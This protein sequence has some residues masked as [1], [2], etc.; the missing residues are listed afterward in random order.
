[1]AKIV[2]AKIQ[3]KVAYT[4]EDGTPGEINAVEFRCV[5]KDVGAGIVGSDVKRYKA[6]IADLPAIFNVSKIDNVTEFCKNLFD[7]E[8]RLQ[9]TASAF[10]GKVTERLVDVTILK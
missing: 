1:M 4:R 2:G 7:K 8:V 10:D 3:E 5:V 6:Q 9:T